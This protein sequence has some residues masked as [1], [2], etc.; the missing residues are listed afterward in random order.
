MAYYKT[1][2]LTAQKAGEIAGRYGY[3]IYDV[4]FVKEG[5]HRFLR[6]YIDRD[7]GVNLDDCEAISREL[8]EYLDAK[9]FIADN[10]FLEVSSPGIERALKTDRHYAAAIGEEVRLKLYKAQDGAKE[11]EGVL[12]DFDSESVTLSINDEKVSIQRKNIAKA[13]IIF[14]F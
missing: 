12:S 10:Y 8:G 13:N 9:D 11:L 7:E 1:E 14:N 4:E 3:E 5:P 2:E 6:V